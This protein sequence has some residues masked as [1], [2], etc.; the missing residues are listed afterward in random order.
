MSMGKRRAEQQYVAEEERKGEREVEMGCREKME[1]FFVASL[2][3]K[4]LS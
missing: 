2:R 1:C 3:H 4:Q